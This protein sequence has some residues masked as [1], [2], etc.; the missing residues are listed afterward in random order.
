MSQ[1]VVDYRWNDDAV[2]AKQALG[3]PIG[4]RDHF[5]VSLRMR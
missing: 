2:P 3:Q 5:G 4:D 1:L